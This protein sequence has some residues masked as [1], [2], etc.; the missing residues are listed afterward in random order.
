ML[1]ELDL[2]TDS[3]K[4]HILRPNANLECKYFKFQHSKSFEKLFICPFTWSA[5]PTDG[6]GIGI[7]SKSGMMSVDD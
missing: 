7:D 4:F 6:S 3:K 5:G 1:H 2:R